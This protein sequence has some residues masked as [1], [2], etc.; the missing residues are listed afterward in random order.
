MS[1]QPSSRLGRSLATAI[2]TAQV[3]ASTATTPFSAECFQ[4]RVASTLGAFLAIGDS[5]ISAS[6]SD[7]FLPA[8]TIDYFTVSPG[9]SLAFLSTSTSTGYFSLTEMI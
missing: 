2:S 4:V 8:N 9:Q 3:N 6:A 1:R 5:S 7:V